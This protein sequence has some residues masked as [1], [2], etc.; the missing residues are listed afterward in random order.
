MKS[1]IMFTACLFLGGM[2]A[3][4]DFKDDAETIL[5]VLQ[6]NIDN[7]DQFSNC[8]NTA[9]QVNGTIENKRKCLAI[10]AKKSKPNNGR[11]SSLRHSQKL[12]IHSPTKMQN[13]RQCRRFNRWGC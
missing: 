5:R 3:S 12:T 4:S 7:I 9:Y 10:L 1:A 6:R 2:N 13:R 11:H 8:F